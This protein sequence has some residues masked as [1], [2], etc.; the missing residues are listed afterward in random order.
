[1]TE[2]SVDSQTKSALYDNGFS[3]LCGWLENLLCN[4][5]LVS[6][7]MVKDKYEEILKFR[8]EPFTE[9]MIRTQ[10]IRDSSIGDDGI[11]GNWIADDLFGDNSSCDEDFGSVNVYELRK[12]SSM[13]I[14]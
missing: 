2:Y 9:G 13:S 14:I 10:S 5:F 6:L 1:M 11:D 8:K 7:V 4:G 3:E 12:S